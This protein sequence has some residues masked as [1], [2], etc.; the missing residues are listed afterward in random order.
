MARGKRVAF[1]ADFETTTDPDDCRVWLWGIAPVEE[2]T[3]QAWGTSLDSFI[4]KISKA[5][6]V[7]SFHNL[8]F[9][10]TFIID[11]L[12]KHDYEHFEGDYAGEP[13]S[14]KTLI[15]DMGKFY[16]FTVYWTSGKITEFR[17]SVKKSQ[18]R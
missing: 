10:G 12:L 11:W 1:A 2:P 18:C 13:G 7:V 15:S 6:S 16:S 8:K 4:H 17:D 3:A 9:D 14:F 5:S